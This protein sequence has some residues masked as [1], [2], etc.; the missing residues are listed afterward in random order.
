MNN[1]ERFFEETYQLARFKEDNDG[2]YAEG[3]HTAIRR[4]G[5]FD[6][7]DYRSFNASEFHWIK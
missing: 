1:L 6:N 3:L 2:S 4:N 7:F 5:G